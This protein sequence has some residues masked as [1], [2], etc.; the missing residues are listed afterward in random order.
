MFFDYKKQNN[1]GQGEFSLG[2]IFGA[3]MCIAAAV[4]IFFD[5]FLVTRMRDR[6]HGSPTPA[7]ENHPANEIPT[8]ETDAEKEKVLR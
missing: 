3:L 8:N 7:L 2:G 1:L 4:V 6:I 5:Q